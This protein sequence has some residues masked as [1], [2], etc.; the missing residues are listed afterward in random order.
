MATMFTVCRIFLVSSVSPV[1]DPSGRISSS[2]TPAPM[3]CC[4]GLCALWP[5]P[6]GHLLPSS[7]SDEAPGEGWE[8]KASRCP[9]NPD[10]AKEK[11]FLQLLDEYLACNGG[12][13]LPVAILDIWA[14]QFNA[15]FGGVPAHSMT[16]YQKKERMKNIY[17]GWKMLQGQTGLGYDK[18][19][20]RVICSD[21]V[22]QSFINVYKECNHLRYE[23][24]RY[25]ELYFNVFE[26]IHTTGVS[27]YGSVTMRDDST[28]YVA[29]DGSMDNSGNQTALDDDLTPTTN[30]RQWTNT[31]L[32]ADAG[33]SRSRGSSGKRKQRDETDDMTFI[34]MQEINDGNGYSTRSEMYDVALLRFAP[35]LPS[36]VPSAA[37][38]R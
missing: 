4:Q 31:R 7:S 13:H 9:D 28:T 16:L 21:E 10:S 11:K 23:G 17:R 32:G 8:K 27:G 37:R 25:K 5:H 36:Y 33:S 20:D 6:I 22:W 29:N 3:C 12:K 14:T 2:S 35:M 15:E 24:L 19:S 18:A 1:P 34:A 26:K 38:D 30:A